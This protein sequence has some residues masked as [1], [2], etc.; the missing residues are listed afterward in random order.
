MDRA[1]ITKRVN[2]A[3][4]GGGAHG[5][6]GWGVLDK[7]LEDGRLGIEGLSATSAGSMNA[8]VYAHGWIRGGTDGAREALEKFWRGIADAGRLLQPLPGLDLSPLYPLVQSLTAAL[9][10]YQFNPF[11]F[12]PLRDL[13]A[14]TLDF[15]AIHACD[16]LELF[17][18][19]TNVRTGQP[20]VFRNEQV[21]IDA[22]MASACLPF[23]F[24]AVE[25]D[26]EHY[27]DGGYMGNPALYPLIYHTESRDVVIV[28]INPILRPQLPT[29]AADIHN[30]LN[31]ITFNSSLL[32]ELRAIAF[33]TKMI[34]QGW[35]KDE[36]RSKL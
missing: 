24:Q 35:L 20:R 2:L 8:A 18:C 23:L 28:H 32:R 27:W 14:K 16:S 33:V 5:A 7:I 3:L 31:E 17:I 25:I 29:T 22:L 13:L 1:T 11:N 4:Q 26:G 34:E 9:S 21:T 6:F 36:Y 19:A 12:N 10:P 15:N 30:R